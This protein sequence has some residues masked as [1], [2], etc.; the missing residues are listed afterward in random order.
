ME[1]AQQYNIEDSI[2]PIVHFSPSDVSPPPAPKHLTQSSDKRRRKDDRSSISTRSARGS[3]REDSSDEQDELNSDDDE[4]RLR[5]ARAWTKWEM[6][7]SKL[8]VDL[9][10]VAEAEKD[11]FAKYVYLFLL[12]SDGGM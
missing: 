6:Y 3:L 2:K 1:I 5:A 12:P 8:H 9:A 4:T 11:D 10:R 7:T